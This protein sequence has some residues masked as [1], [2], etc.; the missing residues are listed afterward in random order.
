MVR[1]SGEGLALS[2][3][4]VILV[5]FGLILYLPIIL[6]AGMTPFLDF[7]TNQRLYPRSW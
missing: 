1:R 5:P 6:D 4:V 3:I 7:F 2:L